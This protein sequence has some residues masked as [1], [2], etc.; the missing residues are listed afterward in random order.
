MKKITCNASDIL[1]WSTYKLDDADT[2][3]ICY[4]GTA[5][6]VTTA[7]DEARKEGYKVGMFRVVTVWPSPIEAI[8]E[9]GDKVKRV[10]VVEHNYG[11]Y[12]LEVERIIKNN[13]CKIDF[14][15]KIDGT[16]IT[17]SEIIKKIKEVK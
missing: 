16:V 5:R 8:K 4:G 2:A 12:L 3:I 7:I 13:N 14:L 9:L 15:G 11:Q 1:E 17:P 10:I 6:S